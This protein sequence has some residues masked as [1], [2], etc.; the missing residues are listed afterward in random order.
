MRMGESFLIVVDDFLR[1]VETGEIRRTVNAAQG[2]RPDGLP[3]AAQDK[4][5]G[6]SWLSI[7]CVAIDS[8]VS[9]ASLAVPVPRLPCGT[10]EL[11]ST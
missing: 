10:A 11:V 8:G 7:T 4:G 5:E 9:T 3:Q 1:V 6:R 2:E